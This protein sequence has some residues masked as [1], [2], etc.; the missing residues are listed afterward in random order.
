VKT[1]KA[2]VKKYPGYKDAENLLQKISDGK[3]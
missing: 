2:I 1:L 3:Q